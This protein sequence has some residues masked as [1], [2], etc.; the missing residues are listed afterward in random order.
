MN[1]KVKVLFV[2]LLTALP[3]MAGGSGEEGHH[4]GFDTHFIYAQIL[5]FVLFFGLLGYILKKPVQEF[6]SGRVA[7][8]RESLAVAEKSR[9]E[10][11]RQLDEIEA[12]SANLDSELADIREQAVKDVAREKE[13]LLALAESEAVRVREQAETD[14]EN[15]RRE[16]Q[17]EL[18]RFL[19]NLAVKEAEN[20][21]R[22][23]MT[24]EE[25][26]KLFV[27]FTS[28]LEAKS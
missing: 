27:D 5:N 3:L 25:R 28:R 18:K 8:I 6:F 1:H 7:T 10:A 4:S 20:V 26:N 24:D 12:K 17:H 14:I 22:N 16:A 23:T 15:M 19:A 9:E 13:R 2:L 21:I 11:K